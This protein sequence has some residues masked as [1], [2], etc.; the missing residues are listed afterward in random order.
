MIN[1]LTRYIIIEQIKPFLF[2]LSVMAGIIW[3]VKSL[4]SLEYIIE[5]NQ[6]VTVFA[7]VIIY[8]LPSV[9]LIV[10]P[11]AA[12]AATSFT[13][14][15]L[16]SEAEFITMMNSGISN[17][18]LFRPFFMFSI[19]ISIFL[20]LLVFLIA[21]TSQKNL[22]EIMYDAGN[23]LNKQ[24][25]QVKKHYSPTP[26][27]SVY[28]GGLN[29]RNELEHILI[30]DDRQENISIT[31]SAKTGNMLIN[32]PYIDLHLKNGVMQSFNK[33]ENSLILTNF[34]FLELNIVDSLKSKH[35]LKFGPS[36]M[37]PTQMLKKAKN[38]NNSMSKKY[39]AEAHLRIVLIF[40][41]IS[42][43]VFSFSCFLLWGYSRRGYTFLIFMIFFLALTMQSSTFASK[44]LFQS[45]KIYWQV[46]YLPAIL[47]FLFGILSIKY[48]SAN[49]AII[50]FR[51]KLTN[52]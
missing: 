38:L 1:R 34:G 16:L 22:R 24:I 28:I 25:M 5:Y 3:L 11:F 37:S 18:Q 48:L 50:P 21:P 35:S 15:R 19:S 6:P 36:E 17:F 2:F 40:T 7:Q 20:F 45:E 51:K 44:S 46:I 31:Y 49:L 30:T 23:N 9:L 33:I 41:P 52:E 29:E 39:S 8:I 4:P 32:D 14:N 13:M 26:N 10:T 27:I 12:L 43:C 42:L 47:T